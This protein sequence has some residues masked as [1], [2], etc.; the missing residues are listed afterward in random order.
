MHCASLGSLSK[1]DRL[2]EALK[3]KAPRLPDTANFLLPSGYEVRKNYNGADYVFYLPMDSKENAKKFIDIVQPDL[4]IW[5]KY[6]YWYHYLTAL[7]KRKIPTLLVSGIFR[8]DQ[9]F[10][11]WYGRLHQYILESFTPPVCANTWLP[12][13]YWPALVSNPKCNGQW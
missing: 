4:V 8:P 2:L 9:P 1:A 11:K 10:F 6:E 13:T 5:I 7:K 3:Q 12:K